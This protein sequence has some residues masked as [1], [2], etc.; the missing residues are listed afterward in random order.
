MTISAKD[1]IALTEKMRSEFFAQGLPEYMWDGVRRYL[2][3]GVCTSDF[4]QG[5]LE[6]SLARAAAHADDRNKQLLFEWAGFM[7]NALPLG[8]W[9]SVAQVDD[10]RDRGGMLGMLNQ[11]KSP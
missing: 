3:Y 1:E 2:L 10:W 8:S 4:L 9:G 7:H 5:A 6:N 11:E